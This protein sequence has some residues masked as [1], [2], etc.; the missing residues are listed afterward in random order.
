MMKLMKCAAGTAIAVLALTGCGTTAAGLQAE[1][2]SSSSE[3]RAVSADSAGP[4]MN[5]QVPQESG[6][7]T[8]ESV[9]GLKAFTYY[10]I[11]YNSYA[12]QTGNVD[13]L[14][15]ISAEECT[16]CT[17]EVTMIKDV[18]ADG[19]WMAGA[20]P[21]ISDVHPKLPKGKITGTSL[22]EYSETAGTIF[23]ADGKKTSTIEPKEQTILTVKASYHEGEWTMQ[24]I[25]ET[26]DAKLPA[27]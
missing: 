7:L 16:Y 12:Q 27:E 1:T 24:S 15:S 6:L 14:K 20:D 21:R 11:S 23:N 25:E 10:W 4:A 19:G 26:P 2:N 5:V 9:E 17:N 8:K 13:T 22:V 3:D 18:Y